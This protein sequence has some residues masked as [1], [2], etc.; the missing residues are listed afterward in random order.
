MGMAFTDALVEHD[1]RARVVL[2]DRRHGVGGH[3]LEAYPFVQLHQSSTFYGVASTVLGGGR[4]SRA[5]RRRGCTSGPGSP[6][7]SPTTPQVLADR[8][9]GSGRVEFL[10][11]CDYRGDR[12]VVSRVSG[13]GF[14]GPRQL[15]GGRRA[16]P[17]ARH[18]GGAAA[19]VRGRGRR[20]RRAGQRPRAPRGGTEPVRRRR[21]RQDGDRCLRLAA[22]SRRRPGRDLLGAPPR[23]VDAQ[24]RADPAGP[25][26]L[27]RH[28]RLDDGGG[29]V[30]RVARRAVP[31]ASRTPGSCCASTA[32]SPRRWPRRPP[33]APGSSSCSGA[34]STSSASGT[35]AP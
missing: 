4:C 10:P 18:P 35:S 6:R 32:R 11:G 24:P 29:R 15:P 34:S 27:P 13:Q 31:R 33:S 19:A 25:G 17:R 16:L 3:W 2:V 30:G 26:H 21:V 9:L 1:P 8:L 28:G 20:A 22:G 14:D 23:A 7:S 5:G 12:T